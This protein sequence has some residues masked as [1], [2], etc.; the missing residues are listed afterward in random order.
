MKKILGESQTIAVIGASDKQHRASYGVMRFLQEKGFRCIPVSPRLAGKELLG[1]TV[2]ASLA[3]IPE[4]VDMVD[5]FI[6]STAAGA[7]TDDAIEIGAKFVWMQLGVVN[8][9]AAERARDAGLEII[10]D[11]CPAQEW[12]ALGL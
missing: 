10:M 1:E 4:R 12:G 3:D 8:E 11:R 5:M 2:Y 9:A 6:N 7:L